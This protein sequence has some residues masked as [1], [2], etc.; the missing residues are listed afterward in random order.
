[1]PQGQIL[2]GPSQTFLIKKGHGE[3]TGLAI[4]PHLEDVDGVTNSLS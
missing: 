2:A 3:V 1:M 4:A